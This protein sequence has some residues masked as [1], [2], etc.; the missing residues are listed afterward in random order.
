MADEAG[1]AETTKKCPRC[2]ETIQ[3]DA[4]VCR[5]C[6]Y[7]YQFGAVPQQRDVRAGTNG[8]SI[9]SLVLGILWLYG[10]GSILALIFGYKGKNEV[11][12]SQG[13]QGG[14]GLA[15]AGI[16]L[17]WVGVAGAILSILLVLS[18]WGGGVQTSRTFSC[19]AN[20]ILT[21]ANEC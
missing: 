18:I 15:I 13:A 19:T 21:S 11:D 14:R 7:D 20:S 3:A 4:L 1:T 6:G 17:G 2:A 10:V 16:V 5:F 12:R 8:M 9:A